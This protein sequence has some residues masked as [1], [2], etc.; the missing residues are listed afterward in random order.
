MRP[1]LSAAVARARHLG[2]ASE[3]LGLLAAMETAD[4][5]ATWATPHLASPLPIL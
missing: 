3:L 2:F 4:M 1:G 5:P